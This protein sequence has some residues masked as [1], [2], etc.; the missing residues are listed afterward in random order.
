MLSGCWMVVQRW[1]LCFCPTDVALVS[2]SCVGNGWQDGEQGDGQVVVGGIR[3]PVVS[4]TSDIGHKKC[5]NPS[6]TKRRPTLLASGW[7]F[8]HLPGQ[9][10]GILHRLGQI[11]QPFLETFPIAAILSLSFYRDTKREADEV[12]SVP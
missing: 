2:V 9:G 5:S 12:L 10:T 3:C 8:A 4:M 7:C 6:E 11:L 1:G